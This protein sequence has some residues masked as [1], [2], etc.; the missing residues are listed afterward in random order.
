M[1]MIKTRPGGIKLLFMFATIAVVAV[2]LV[3][4]FAVPDENGRVREDLVVGDY[5]A[6]KST[7]FVREFTISEING[8]ELTVVVYEEGSRYTT[9]MAKEA[10]LSHILAWD[11]IMDEETF[12]GMVNMKT[13]FGNKV[14]E[15]HSHLISTYNIGE[16][17][18]IYGCR[19]GGVH[20]VLYDTSLLTG[21]KGMEERP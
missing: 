12:V 13:I 7:D 6:L 10:F 20:W 5:I 8:D 4:T 16:Y 2:L 14:C 3:L 15:V 9:T 19:V 1:D 17:G 21:Y 18:V 11:A